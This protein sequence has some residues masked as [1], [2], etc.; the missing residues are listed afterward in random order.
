VPLI[1]LNG[2]YWSKRTRQVARFSM[3][4]AL[5]VLAGCVGWFWRDWR[6]RGVLPVRYFCAFFA[7]LGII[8]ALLYY[9]LGVN[10]FRRTDLDPVDDPKE[11]KPRKTKKE[12]S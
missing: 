8:L 7:G 4:A 10:F 9:G 2:K 5:V 3:F 1:D 12:S 11:R 6:I